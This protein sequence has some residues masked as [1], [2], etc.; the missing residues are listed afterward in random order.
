MR[1]DAAIEGD[2]VRVSYLPYRKDIIHPYDVL[3]DIAISYG[4]N[5]MMPE[6]PEI[7]TIG[8]LEPITKALKTIRELVIGMGFQEVL[9]FTLSSNEAL[10]D[11]MH[12]ERPENVVEIEN[13]VSMSWSVL[14]DWLTPSLLSFLSKNTH[15]DYPQNI[16]ELSEAVSED[17]GMETR[18]ESRYKLAFALCNSSANFTK[19]MECLDNLMR[20]MG[21]AYSVRQTEHTSFLDGR[22]G[23]IIVE[24]VEYG[25]I[26]EIH[27]L[28]LEEWGIENPIAIVELEIERLCK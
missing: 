3:E 19:A 12:V 28:V 14:R 10:Y 16:F 15:R 9:S 13:P 2:E 11:K 21:K 26:G 27:P 8:R 6:I 25:L 4:F 20:N 23:K 18:V 24:G 22:V 5:D 7:Y 1:Y 17:P